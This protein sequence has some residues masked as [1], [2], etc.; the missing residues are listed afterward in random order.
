MQRGAACEVLHFHT[1][2]HTVEA[3]G[4][5]PPYDVEEAQLREAGQRMRA[6]IGKVASQ[7]GWSCPLPQ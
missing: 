7:L 5:T 4:L 6:A 1:G 2:Q 3:A